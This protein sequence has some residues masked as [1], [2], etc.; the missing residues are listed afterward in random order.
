MTRRTQS[1][2]LYLLGFASFFLLFSFI[3]SA[4]DCGGNPSIEEQLAA[5]GGSFRDALAKDGAKCPSE[6]TP[7][8]ED[9]DCQIC[10]DKQLLCVGGLCSRMVYPDDDHTEIQPEPNFDDHHREG[11][12]PEPPTCPNWCSSH[13]D[14]PASACGERTECVNGV[15]SYPAR[16]CPSQCN[17]NKDCQTPLCGSK[18]H[19]HLRQC[20]ELPECPK[21][22]SKDED[23]F[24]SACGSHNHC[25][26]GTCQEASQNHAPIAIVGKD[27]KG[28]IGDLITLDGSQ[29]NDPDGDKLTF[30]WTFTKK[31]AKSNTDFND[32]T[33]PK[34]SFV[35]DKEGEYIAQLVVNDGHIDS[36]PAL[37]HILISKVPL[38]DPILMKIAPDKAEEQN[39]PPKLALFG[40]HFVNGSTVVF[41]NVRLPTTFINKTQLLAQLNPQL[42]V[43]SYKVFVSNPN[44]QKSHSLTFT[45]T[46]RPHDPPKLLRLDPPE[47]KAKKPFILT[48][49]GE[50]FLKGASLIFDNTSYPTTF[51]DSK[52]LKTKIAPMPAGT[53]DVLI[54]NPDALK[55]Q[56]LTFKVA[57][58]HT[59]PVLH[60]LK[61]T[62]FYAKQPFLLV[63]KG[64]RFAKN[65]Q[66][67]I[68]NQAYLAQ[69][70][71]STELRATI[72]IPTVGDFPVFVKN[73]NGEKSNT[74]RILIKK[75]L[76]RPII[77]KLNPN[78]IREQ[79]AIT[80]AVLG[81]DFVNGAKVQLNGRDFATTFVSKTEV[82]VTLPNTL[83]AGTYKV[84]LINPDRQKSNVMP[85]TLTP[86]PP[87]PILSKLTPSRVPFGMKTTLTLE[88]KFFAKGAQLQ[89]GPKLYT[90]QFL[91]P[92]KLTVSFAATFKP[93]TYDVILFNPDRQKSNALKLTIYQLPKPVLLSLSP[94]TGISGKPLTIILK[95]KNFVKTS[96]ALF[97]GGRQT[98]TFINS[99]ELRMTLSLSSM[100]AGTYYIWVQNPDSQISA[101][102]PF[103]VTAPQ[104]PQI[105]Q[106]LPNKGYSNANV[107]V[108]IDGSG[109][110]K[111]ATVTLNKT[112]FKTNYLNA[113][114]LG[115]TFKLKGFAA[116]TYPVIITNPDKKISN[117]AYF[118]VSKV[119]LHAPVLISI[120]PKKLSLKKSPPIYISGKYFQNGALL[121]LPLPM[122]GAIG[123][124][125]NFI[126]SNTL[127]MTSQLPS[128]PFPFGTRTVQVYIKNPD[129]QISNKKPLQI[130]N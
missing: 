3:G 15:C 10:G 86:K 117:T 95:G 73:P 102:L 108:I 38:A 55:S 77:T 36:K 46:A 44:G 40:D 14:C 9:K 25:I 76:T 11:F 58:V 97:Q 16:K 91:T 61:P 34:P 121:M 48:A 57:V 93:A 53:Y 60:S 67:I 78:R 113:K 51:I 26:N 123:L 6:L 122:V 110:L 59:E 31:P 39:I 56:A 128:I 112:T 98:T 81:N 62:I 13:D 84:Q 37:L 71:S 74:L 28:K 43:G 96:Q 100:G 27:I 65:A 45:V 49:Y 33:L 8:I 2:R 105:K 1:Y 68:N 41:D 120:N 42:K 124:P 63:L 7:C 90:T 24:V 115:A 103:K 118:T 54:K 114:T 85:L 75:P 101:K 17:S 21:T 29:S 111:G 30:Q 107:N 79:T 82:R 119:Q 47:A 94:N 20:S 4:C 18:I 72:S 23:C 32:S 66:I 12:K 64:L 129:K 109:F 116:G 130:S 22:C 19:C 50:K 35:P 80:F 126:N 87:A 127:V 70:I 83:K 89:I 99:T 69:F 104:G 88:G 92:N 52:T 106:L 5:D 125:T